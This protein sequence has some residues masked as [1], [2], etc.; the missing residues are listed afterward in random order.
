VPSLLQEL[1]EAIRKLWAPAE[2]RAILSAADPIL[3]FDR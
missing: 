1:G 2:E 3:E